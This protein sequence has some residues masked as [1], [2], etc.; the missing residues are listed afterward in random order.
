MEINF[1]LDRK[2]QELVLLLPFGKLV[3]LDKKNIFLNEDNDMLIILF[4]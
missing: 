2:Y 3:L 4:Q 1:D